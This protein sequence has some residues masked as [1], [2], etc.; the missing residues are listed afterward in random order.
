MTRWFYILLLRMHPR[1]FR[2]RF[3]DE[4]LWIFDSSSEKSSLMADGFLSLVRQWTMRPPHGVAFSTTTTADGVPLFYSAEPEIPRVS[5]MMPGALITLVAFS[6]ISFTMSHRWRQ[7]SLMVGSHHPSPSHLLGAHTEAQPL[8]DL[9][10]EVKLKPY[11]FHPPIS[12]YFRFILVLSAL[13]VDQDNVISAAEMENA[14]AALWKLDKNHDGKLSAEECGLEPDPNLD[15]MLLGRMRLTFMRVHPVLAAL[16][17]NH[18]GEI[19]SDEIRNAAAALRA[20]DANGDGKLVEREL[21]P[22]RAMADA[23]GMMDMLDRNGDGKITP[24]ERSG[25]VGARFRELLDRADRDGKGFVTEEDLVI[26]FAVNLRRSSS[27]GGSGPS[28]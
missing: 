25:A 1:M 15:P 2:Q 26:A 3:G 17:T 23:A 13:D 28:K 14:P 7:T 10:A 6:L 24:D 8:A 4:M 20:L 12:A 27:L 11:P 19:S 22:D 18:D 5:M 21:V 16:D 9:P